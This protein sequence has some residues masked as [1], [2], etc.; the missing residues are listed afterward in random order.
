MTN[1]ET[2]PAEQ[3]RFTRDAGPDDW[4]GLPR[5]F[6]EGDIVTRYHGHTYGLDRDD[7]LL[8]GVETIACTAEGRRAFFTVPV[9]YLKATDGS[10]PVGEYIKLDAAPKSPAATEHTDP[11]ERFNSRLKV[12]T[13]DNPDP[14]VSIPQ[15]LGVEL[16]NTIHSLQGEMEKLKEQLQPG[17]PTERAPTQWAYDQACKAL[18]QR[19]DEL[20]EAKKVLE[21]FASY[22]DPR[23]RAPADMPITH[24]SPMAKRQLTMGDCY[25]AADL[26]S[27][28]KNDLDSSVKDVGG[29][30]VRVAPKSQL[31]PPAPEKAATAD[32]LWSYAY[33]ICGRKRWHLEDLFDAWEEVAYER[34]DFIE[35]GVFRKPTAALTDCD[36]EILKDY[37]EPGQGWIAPAKWAPAVARPETENANIGGK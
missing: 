37:G 15:S 29:T 14:M 30:K 24:G 13:E 19:H 28:I 26:V 31:Q 20:S 32:P 4:P 23:R 17:S 36:L 33:T 35:C 7:L 10:Q 6:E 34:F 21:R 27:R 12:P 22:A 16:R 25:D 5:Q 9:T 8:M 2:A 3:Y 11:L 18:R 1:D